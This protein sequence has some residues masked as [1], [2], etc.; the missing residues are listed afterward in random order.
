M[1]KKANKQDRATREKNKQVNARNKTTRTMS[2][3]G[4]AIAALLVLSM[5]LSSL[6]F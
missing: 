1:N 3:V 4:I 6:R 2:I 5:V